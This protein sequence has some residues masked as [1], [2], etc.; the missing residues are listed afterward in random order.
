MDGPEPL[1]RRVGVTSYRQEVRVAMPQPRHLGG[2][3]ALVNI[4][5][6]DRNANWGDMFHLTFNLGNRDPSGF[7]L[8]KTEGL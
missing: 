6:S 8:F 3:E 4:P 2:T 1:I 5:S 7:N